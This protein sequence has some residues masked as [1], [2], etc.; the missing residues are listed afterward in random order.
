MKRV[1]C[2]VCLMVLSGCAS[3]NTTRYRFRWWQGV[4]IMVVNDCRGADLT[5]S[6]MNGTEGV[7]PYGGERRVVLE[8][9]MAGSRELVLTARGF[10]GGGE[11]LGSASQRYHLGNQSRQEVWH[12]R[13]LS[14][15]AG[16]GRVR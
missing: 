12:V 2:A 15:G 10:S 11:Y 1:L 9:R 3:T 5:L 14:G 13:H 4:D 7:I 8:R 16:C 6:S